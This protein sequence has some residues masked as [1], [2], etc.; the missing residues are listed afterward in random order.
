[1]VACFKIFIPG[2]IEVC[3]ISSLRQVVSLMN[4]SV[5]VY[6]VDFFFCEISG[7][8]HEVDDNCALLGYYAG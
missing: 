7:L 2:L 3:N 5:P 8:R 1:L 6:F 4:P